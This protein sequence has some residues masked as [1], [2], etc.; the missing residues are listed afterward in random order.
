MTARRRRG[1]GGGVDTS[2]PGRRR[3]HDR[4]QPHGRQSGGHH[5]DQG[6]RDPGV[7]DSAS[8]RARKGGPRIVILA[9]GAEV[10]LAGEEMPQTPELGKRRC[11][12]PQL[13][14]AP[15]DALA[16]CSGRHI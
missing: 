10:P 7:A 9:K 13:T 12:L 4:R 11:P 15:T 3:Q 8:G 5:L 6:P 2:R 16:R 14:G 1:V